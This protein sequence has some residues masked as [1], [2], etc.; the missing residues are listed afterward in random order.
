MIHNCDQ[1]DAPIL[2]YGRMIPCKHVFCYKCA[3][4]AFN[5]TSTQDSS[6]DTRTTNASVQGTTKRCPRC[7]D[8]VVR[9]EQAGL[10]SIYMCQHGGSRSAHYHQPFS[11]SY[12]LPAAKRH[13][14]SELQ[15]ERKKSYFCCFGHC[16]L[17]SWCFWYF[18]GI[19]VPIL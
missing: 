1:C 13:G 6:A 9:V 7:K 18:F 16:N 15:V 14:H 17:C 2:I 4:A 12:F 8:K 10:G 11:V 5:Q 19:I 3:L